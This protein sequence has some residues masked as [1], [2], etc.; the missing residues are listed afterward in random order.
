VH[1]GSMPSSGTKASDAEAVEAADCKPAL[2]QF[3]SEPV[4]QVF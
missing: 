4:L 1:G 2:T 3:E